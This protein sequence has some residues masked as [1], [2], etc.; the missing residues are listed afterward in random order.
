MDD[1]PPLA[2]D[3]GTAALNDLRENFGLVK[4]MILPVFPIL[5]VLAV[6]DHLI[7]ITF[8]DENGKALAITYI[9]DIIYILLS[10][11]VSVHYIMRW[12]L[13]TLKG[14]I[15]YEATW[16]HPDPAYKK[17]FTKTLILQVIMFSAILLP[18]ILLIISPVI[19][20][21]LVL[22]LMCF[23][24]YSVAR[25]SFILPATVLGHTP[26]LRQIWAFASGMVGKTLWAPM[27]VCFVYFL[28]AIGYIVIMALLLAIFGFIKEGET[29]DLLAFTLFYLPGLF[30]GILFGLIYVGVLSRYYQW[31]LDHRT[32]AYGHFK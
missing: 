21:M 1:S 23:G 30:F 5:I 24:I 8:I 28:A 4:K 18:L 17:F 12:H 22:P 25:F 31:G 29:N 2:V 11:W 26:S 6:I 7:Q 20:L 19:G 32:D 13:F 16:S 15:E 3:I 27:R 10:A 9:A 14:S